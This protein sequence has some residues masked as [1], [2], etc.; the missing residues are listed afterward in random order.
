M[1]LRRHP[2]LLVLAGAIVATAACSSSPDGGAGP[3]EA[4]LSSSGSVPASASPEAGAPGGPGS[5]CTSDASALRTFAP[6]PDGGGIYGTWI[7]DRYGLPAFE[8]QLDERTDPRGVRPNSEDIV[9]LNK[10]RTDH[11][12]VMG[13]DRAKFIAVDDG[14]VTLFGD[15]RGPTFYNR[16][17]EDQQNLG[18][19]F[20]YVKD[21]SQTYATMFKYAPAGART[22]RIFGMG[23]YETET[24][25]G[26]LLVRHTIHAPEGDAAF[27]IDDVV[28][29]NTSS[30][31]KDVQ[32]YEYWDVNRHQIKSN[33]VRTGL[34]AAPSDAARDGLNDNFDQQVAWDAAQKTLTATMTA[35]GATP[36][37]SAVSDI[38]WYPAPVYLTALSGN[39]DGV[40][41]DQARF[42]GG[43]V[44]QPDV[45]SRGN[46][47]SDVLARRSASGQPATLAMRSDLTIEAG[48]ERSLRFAY[49]YQPSGVL[50]GSASAYRGNADPLADSLTRWKERLGYVHV[51]GAKYLHRETAW[52]TQALLAATVK[53]DYYGTK[54]TAQGSAY[55]YLHGADGV[56]R[57]Q[58]LY[59]MATS[60]LDPSIAKGTLKQVMSVTD[61]TS[62]QIAY[63]FTNV[64]MTEGAAI[65]NQP[66]DIDIYF[67]LGLSEYLAATGDAAVLDEQVEF[68]PKGSASL[69]PGAGGK[70]VL[71]HARA[72]FTHLR[73]AVG[74]GDH[75]LV[76]L[77]DGDW[78]DG[79]LLTDKSPTAIGNTQRWGESV[80]NSQ[81]AVVALPLAADILGGRDAALASQM[82]TYVAALRPN[83][84]STFTTR[85]FGRAWMHNTINQEYMLHND[86]TSDPYHASGIDLQAQPWGLLGEVLDDANRGRVLDE[87]EARLDT[88]SPAMGPRMAPGDSV[89]PAISQVMTWAYARYRPASAWR[90][91]DDQTYVAHAN[92]F[93]NSWVGVLA[94]PDGLAADGGTWSSPVT[95]MEDFPVANMNPEAMWLIGLLRTAGVEP[96]GNGLLV[97]PRGAPGRDTYVLDLPLLRLEV[98]P[99]RIAG[100][101]R[102]K[103]AGA[104]T[105]TI[106]IGGNT[107]HAS[108][109]GVAVNAPITNGRVALP[110]TFAA[111]ERIVF[112]VT[113]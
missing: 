42:F 2:H 57:D 43:N 13:N 77:A 4:P 35:R 49:G 29:K 88:R 103:N 99:T 86:L 12:H 73:D 8:Y 7:L 61:A 11:F 65:H 55:L 67:L 17:A 62:G 47:A 36:A 76:R 19:G 100:E 20:S 10:K 9:P 92:A 72:A 113:R 97:Q 70:T 31:R 32:H 60:Y 93:P 68:Y 45:V 28:V 39:V 96:L 71:D 104:T 53:N 46:V 6:C 22:R 75:G 38:D 16:F 83:V 27:L 107:S 95:P 108:V 54:Y 87:V 85:W 24:E 34:A 94:A 40:Y 15:E 111:G 102:A 90:S 59:A 84:A 52:R 26:G 66:S 109:R 74:L 112:E 91:L 37:F 30:A 21:G 63:S 41:T 51:P 69:P 1:S 58:S 106:A 105:L 101:Y 33:W 3:A 5:P 14:Y 110:L 25:T 89:W 79:I 48:Q 82:R 23:Y 81:M 18:G 98:S 80:P 50:A 64:G 44:R 56:P 78:D